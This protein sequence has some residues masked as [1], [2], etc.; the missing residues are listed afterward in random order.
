L[1]DKVQASSLQV[2]FHP[3]TGRLY[4]LRSMLERGLWMIKNGE[5][6]RIIRAINKRLVPKLKATLKFS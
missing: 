4:Y 2:F 5:Y 3:G 1:G 6:K